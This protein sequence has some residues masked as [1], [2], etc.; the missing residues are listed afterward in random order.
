MLLV[1]TFDRP[2]SKGRDNKI[3]NA[4]LVTYNNELSEKNKADYVKIHFPL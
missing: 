4:A 3:R 2:Y 1:A